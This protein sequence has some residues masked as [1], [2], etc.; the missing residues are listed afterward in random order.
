MA[1]A[2][3]EIRKMLDSLPD[4]TTWEDVQYSIY[5]RERVERGKAE[6][7]AL[8]N[9]SNRT[10]LNLGWNGGSGNSVDRFG[11]AGTGKYCRLHRSRF[12][13]LRRS[14]RR[15]SQVRRPFPEEIS[16]PRAGRS[17]DCGRKRSR[18]ICQELPI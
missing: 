17:G 6:A 18:N 15:R 5:V 13:S 4:E 8:A 10:R 3:E 16:T 1:S 14:A 2:K 12:S 11:L 7:A 9:S